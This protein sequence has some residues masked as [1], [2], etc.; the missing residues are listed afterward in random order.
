M[1][2]PRRIAFGIACMVTS[3]L[4]VAAASAQGKR[5]WVDPPRELD[6]TRSAPIVAPAPRD[7]SAE[8]AAQ[9]V[10][11]APPKADESQ[12]DVKPAIAAARTKTKPKDEPTGRT[13]SV[14][15]KAGTRHARPGPARTGR[16]TVAAGKVRPG[17]DRRLPPVGEPLVVMNLQTIE[18]PDGRRYQVL[19]DP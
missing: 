9:P 2:S 18:L 19:T 12:A 7:A 1:S 13:A 14:R 4:G 16:T 10:A 17:Q 11:V 3:L 8:K 5:I 15:A 6:S